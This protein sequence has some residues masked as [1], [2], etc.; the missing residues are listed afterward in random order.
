MVRRIVGLA[1]V[2]DIDTI[3]DATEREHAQRKALAIGKTLIKNNRRLNTIGE[4][5]DLV[6]T[7]IS[8]IK[9]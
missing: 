8:S 9:V 3:Q 7:A 6:S 4:V 5:L 2:A 1:H